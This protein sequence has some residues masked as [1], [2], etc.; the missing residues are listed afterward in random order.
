MPRYLISLD[1]TPFKI[2]G[3]LSQHSYIEWAEG[4]PYRAPL[5]PRAA[6]RRLEE[7]HRLAE[8]EP[9]RWTITEVP[10]TYGWR[11]EVK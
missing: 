4:T 7:A 6:Q 9:E 11:T 10:S 5:T 3:V 8:R 1:G 2:L